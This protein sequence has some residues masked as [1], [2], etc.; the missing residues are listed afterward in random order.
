M[1]VYKISDC[2]FISR[3]SHLS[4]NIIIAGPADSGK[5]FL[6]QPLT[7][8]FKNVFINLSS[9]FA[10]CMD[11]SRYIVNAEPNNMG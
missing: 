3:R 9:K 8:V 5:T 10:I 6:L 4:I 7:V 2:G 11:W 1:F